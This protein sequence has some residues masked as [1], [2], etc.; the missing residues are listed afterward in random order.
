MNELGP[1][2]EENVRR[3]TEVPISPRQS[4]SIVPEEAFGPRNK[5]Q[6]RRGDAVF[7]N[8]GIKARRERFSVN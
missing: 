5:W 3:I 6:P 2:R 1:R 4:S 7:S 8:F